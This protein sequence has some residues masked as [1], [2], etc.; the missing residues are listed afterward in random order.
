MD[1]VGD[2]EPDARRWDSASGSGASSRSFLASQLPFTGTVIPLEERKLPPA[3]ERAM[4]M[5]PKPSMRKST[6]TASELLTTTTSPCC[7]VSSPTRFD[8][9]G[10]NLT[11]QSEPRTRKAVG[12]P[13]G[14]G[15]V[16]R[17]LTFYSST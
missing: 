14:T 1:V 15:T 10:L 9:A 12:V 16:W 13:P 3:T 5:N 11:T 17:Q 2:V 4:Q 6:S 8:E 7:A